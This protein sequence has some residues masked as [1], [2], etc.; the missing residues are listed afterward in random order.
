MGGAVVAADVGAVGPGCSGGW[1]VVGGSAARVTVG[2]QELAAV[3]G[4]PDAGDAAN[5]HA[6][7]PATGKGSPAPRVSP[8]PRMSSVL[9]PPGQL[10]FAP[11]TEA[12]FT[13]VLPDVRG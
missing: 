6:G 8:C 4:D 13:P 2:L 5:L 7:R 1:P 9:P 10:A 3:E 12:P 11:H